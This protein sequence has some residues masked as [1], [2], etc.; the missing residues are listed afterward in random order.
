M[1]LPT[2]ARL[3]VVYS[4]LD[5]DV[6]QLPLDAGVAAV[7]AVETSGSE[8]LMRDASA[9]SLRVVTS[10]LWEP[11]DLELGD[12]RGHHVEVRRVDTRLWLLPH[13]GFAVVLDLDVE[14][15]RA[16]AVQ[17]LDLTYFHDRPLQLRGR[18]VLDTMASDLDD[19]LRSRIAGSSLGWDRRQI[20][21][22]DDPDF[23]RP[24]PAAAA[25]RRT[26]PTTRSDT[27]T[28]VDLD[29]QYVT[30]LMAKEHG[31]HR[32]GTSPV[33]LPPYLNGP[34]GSVVA[35][36]GSNTVV[37][38]IESYQINQLLLSSIQVV[39]ATAAARDVRAEAHEIARGLPAGG[40]HGPH[41]DRD[42]LREIAGRLATLQIRLSLG[43]EAHVGT[44]LVAGGRPIM[45]YHEAIVRQVWL[46]DGLQATSRMLDRLHGFVEAEVQAVTLDE[47]LAAERA[48]SQ[49]LAS[50]RA[51]I[52]TTEGARS[53]GIVA[54][55]AA[56]V[57][58]ATGLFAG[59][60]AVPSAGD[61]GTVLLDAPTA[62]SWSLAIVLAALTFGYATYLAARHEPGPIGVVAYRWLT[63]GAVVGAVAFTVVAVVGGPTM[64]PVAAAG[65]L[66]GAA[67]L[68]YA[69]QRRF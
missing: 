47:M 16:G 11:N 63:L 60:A 37:T 12:T 15:T 62:A 36:L 49:L 19:P 55:V 53:A 69:A 40:P 17:L 39:C 64:G 6:A 61:D 66:T 10:R 30:Q 48:Q 18:D 26:G 68:G 38:G 29:T 41:P 32:P 14:V 28:L 21:V 45:Y 50:V 35:V 52:T 31:R 8:R 58:T 42:A 56:A 51:L 13:A 54:A 33:E 43:V 4:V 5:E 24:F 2:T 25:T 22:V 59:L 27:E 23:L 57:L 67:V 1:H 20:L 34:E 7:D 3:L 9:W 46:E 65:A 44:A